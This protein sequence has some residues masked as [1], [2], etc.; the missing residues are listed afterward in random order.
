MK[1]FILIFTIIA[2]W[3]IIIVTNKKRKY[4][5]VVEENIEI[6]NLGS[7]HSY[8]AFNYDRITNKKCTNLANPSQTFYYDYKVLNHFFDKLANNGKCFLTISY[9]SFAGKER[10]LIEDL[11]TY[12]KILKLK[13]FNT[14]EEKLN[15]IIFNFL[16]IIWSIRKKYLKRKKKNNIEKKDR[17]LGHKNMLVENRNLGYNLNILDKII[18]K[19]KEK[20]IE[21][22]LVTTPFTEYYNSYFNKELLEKNFYKII[23]EVVKKYNLKY[24]DLSH[25]YFNFTEKEF[26][27]YDHLSENGSKK[28]MK[29]LIEKNWI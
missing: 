11:V 26:D 4:K 9:F 12:F 15:Y 17:I 14:L 29:Y 19:C 5:K 3:N 13:D 1:I 27:D 23:Y 22:I 16:P 18:S 24:I 10:W 6:F 7:S 8:F 21:V 2:I 28:F 20:N 25:D